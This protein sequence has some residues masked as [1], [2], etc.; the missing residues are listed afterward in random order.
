MGSPV[1][2]IAFMNDDDKL[3]KIAKRRRHPKAYYNAL[4]L[5][6]INYAK[7]TSYELAGEKFQVHPH[8]IHKWCKT[9]DELKML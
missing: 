6:A 9:E 3:S 1:K 2:A 5:E 8:S 4:K 7:E